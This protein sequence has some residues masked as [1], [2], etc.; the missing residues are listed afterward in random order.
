[1]ADAGYRLSPTA[2][3]DLNDIWLFGTERWSMDQADRY[4]DSLVTNFEMIADFPQIARERTEF[5]PPVRVHPTGVHLVI[6]V[7]GQGGVTVL[8][9][10]HGRQ[11]L[12]SALDQ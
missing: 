2:E 5:T 10:L 7:V 8:R 12:L 9:V 11:D 3:A 6:Y 4:I 1:M